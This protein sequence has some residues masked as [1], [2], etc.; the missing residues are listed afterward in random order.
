MTVE[1]EH[2]PPEQLSDA[3]LEQILVELQEEEAE[4][5]RLRRRLHD[6]LASFPN[7]VAQQQEAELSRRRRA[8]HLRIDVLRA[9]R[10]KRRDE[11]QL[12][13]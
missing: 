2:E 5:S 12:D 1:E 13:G 10:S 9:E 11:A 3:E 4:V 6:R 8:L 7:E